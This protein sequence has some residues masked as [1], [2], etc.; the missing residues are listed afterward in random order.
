MIRRQDKFPLRTEFLKLRQK[1]NKAV[2]SHLIIYHAKNDQRP[3]LGVSIP[4]KVSKLATTRN[5][6]K[7]L[8]YDSL[9]PQIK[10]QKLDVVV[11]FKPLPLK[12]NSTIKQLIQGELHV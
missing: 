5:Y 4:K 2:Q 12:K 9:W 7:R 8:T 3:R 11:V 10:D 1:A 6:L